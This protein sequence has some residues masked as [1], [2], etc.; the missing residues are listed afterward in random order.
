MP[1]LEALRDQ[2]SLLLFHKIPCGAVSIEK[3]NYLT[4]AH[5]LKSTRS[6]HSAQYCRYQTYRDALSRVCDRIY[7]SFA[8]I[9]AIHIFLCHFLKLRARFLAIFLHKIRGRF[10]GILHKKSLL[11][12]TPLILVDYS[13]HIDTIT[14]G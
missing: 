7:I 4:P 9:F 11:T 5:I 13:I 8:T 14:M 12:L 3:D 6:S 10:L 2:S 1:S